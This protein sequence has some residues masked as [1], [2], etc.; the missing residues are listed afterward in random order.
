MRNA[1]VAWEAGASIVGGG[2][3]VRRNC[4]RSG[5]RNDI[6]GELFCIAGVGGIGSGDARGGVFEAA[7]Y[8]GGARSDCRDGT[9]VCKDYE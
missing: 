2:V 6:S 4:G 3:F 5:G 7:M 1:E 8:G 9:S